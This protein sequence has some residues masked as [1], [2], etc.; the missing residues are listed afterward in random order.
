[1]DPYRDCPGRCG[2]LGE[3]QA[4]APLPDLAEGR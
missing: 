4:A 3:L 1:M 2:A